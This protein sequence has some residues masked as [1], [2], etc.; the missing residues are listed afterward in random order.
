MSTKRSSSFPLL[1]RQFSTAMSRLGCWKE[2]K[3]HEEKGPPETNM[4]P[5]GNLCARV[6]VNVSPYVG[7]VS[8]GEGIEPGWKVD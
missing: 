5:R 2:P 3:W 6:Y 8:S 4:A 7:R 1:R